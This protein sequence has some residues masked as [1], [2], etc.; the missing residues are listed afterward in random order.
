[1]EL[2]KQPKQGDLVRHFAEESIRWMRSNTLTH[3]KG[4]RLKRSP[5]GTTLEI[6]QQN[7]NSLESIIALLPH[8]WKCSANGDA[9]IDVG[10]GRIHSFLDGDSPGHNASASMAGFGDWEGGNV[11]VTA[12]TGVIYGELPAINSVSPLVDIIADSA[13][14]Y[15]D[16]NIILLRTMPDPETY[17]TVGFA[18]TM[19]KNP[20]ANVFYWEIAQVAL[21]D[22]IASITKQVLRHD[23]ML[24]N[25]TQ[26]L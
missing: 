26:Y 7:G 9:T 1:M 11:T 24:W 5:N 8:P 16:V 23:P 21:T 6:E 15:G 3:V 4:G 18:E 14:E 22:G 17:I 2:P 10:E 25:F 13:G 12:A 20:S 19:P